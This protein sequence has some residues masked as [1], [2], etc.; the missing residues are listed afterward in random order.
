MKVRESKRRQSFFCKEGG[1]AGNR[2]LETVTATSTANN[3]G[4]GQV[5]ILVRGCSSWEMGRPNNH[6]GP[7]KVQKTEFNDNKRNRNKLNTT[8]RCPNH[9]LRLQKRTGGDSKPLQRTKFTITH[10]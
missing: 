9:E 8:L 4:L 1:C 2:G 6:H 5:S 7:S 3:L 10:K